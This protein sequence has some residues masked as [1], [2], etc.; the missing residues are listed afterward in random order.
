MTLNASTGAPSAPTGPA[1][2][3]AALAL[4]IATA[5]CQ[6][7]PAAQP[8]H[9][10]A[11]RELLERIAA[12]DARHRA[13]ITV[14]ARGAMAAAKRLDE[15]ERRGERLGPLHG[16]V[17]AVKD[18]TAVAG[19]PNTAGTEGLRHFVPQRDATV[20]RRLKDA[21]AVI[22]GKT[23]MHELGFGITSNN[24]AFGAVGNARDPDYMPGGSSGGSAVAV[25]AGWVRASLCTDTGGSCRIPA[26]LNGVV[27]YRP[28]VGRYPSDGLFSLSRT[29]GTIGHI[30]HTVADIALLD[31]AL[32]LE[33]NALAAPAPGE[34]RL[35]VPRAHFYENLDP[36]VAEAVAAA[37]SRLDRAGVTLVEA[38]IEQV[39]EL[40]AKVGF[41]VVFHETARLL[42]KY[43]AD[44]GIPLSP[45]QLHAKIA[46]P[47]VKAVIG[48][49][50]AEG[51]SESEYRQ[52]MDVHRPQLQKTY[53][54][55]FARHRVD[56]VIF[57]T[58][59]LPARPIRGNDETVPLNG[60][61][62]PTFLTYIRNTDPGSNAGV[63]GLSLP[64]DSGDG[65]PIGMALDGLAGADRRLMAIGQALAGVLANAESAGG[66]R[67]D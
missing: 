8:S 15:A 43:L 63:P 38:E 32:R 49:I 59:P 45:E 34:I 12:E 64:L 41:P 67:T 56:A 61:R 52:A 6:P 2:F 26:A 28:T 1:R 29:R 35:G 3:A 66:A 60:E 54:E 47:D 31:S 24:A 21:G 20:V 17:L 37:L 58:T 46:S 22:V 16:F 10:E 44:N 50:L 9:A 13:F 48:A 18:N 5:A 53:A 55:Y 27:G 42:P 14:D 51:G 4:G 11:L 23:N 30:A 25:A 33:P 36:A 65:M 40:N 39:T 57:P 62:A 7:Q 19:L